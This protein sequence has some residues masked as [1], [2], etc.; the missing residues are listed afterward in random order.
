MT[1]DHHRFRRIVD[2]QIDSGRCFQRPN[3]AAFPADNLSF[4]FV[5]GQ[6]ENGNRALG[7]KVAG[8]FARRKFTPE[9]ILELPGWIEQES[10]KPRPSQL[11][12]TS[13]WPR[14]GHLRVVK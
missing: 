9:D 8:S 6:R 14:V 5:V 13:L 1:R 4:E 2:D 12:D 10:A 11:M 7:D 3:I